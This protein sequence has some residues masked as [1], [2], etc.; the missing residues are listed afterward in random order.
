MEREK[1]TT[2]PKWLIWKIDK[3]R[4][5]S[6]GYWEG[7]KTVTEN[8]FQKEKN[9]ISVELKTLGEE[10]KW[11]A[12]FMGRINTEGNKTSKHFTIDFKKLS[13]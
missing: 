4:E 9:F 11:E 6:F 7:K 12:Y 10:Q 8:N 3:L 13:L 5:R 1:K 2:K